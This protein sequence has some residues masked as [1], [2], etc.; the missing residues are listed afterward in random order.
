MFCW[1][2]F[3]VQPDDALSFFLNSLGDS[4]RTS[5][6][7]SDLLPSDVTG[8]QVLDRNS[9]DFVL[10]KGPFLPIASGGRIESSSGADAVI[11]PGGHAERQVT[12]E[13]KTCCFP[14]PLWFS[15]AKSDRAR[16]GLSIARSSI[17]S[18]SLSNSCW[19]PRTRARDRDA[20]SP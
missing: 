10:R 17:G 19:I 2:G 5:A 15:D 18:F 13:G 9:S 7:Y 4:F 12:I 16:R 1:K 14:N 6:V 20:R 11:P 8:T 3:Q